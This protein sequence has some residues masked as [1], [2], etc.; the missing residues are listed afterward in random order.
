MKVKFNIHSFI[1]IITNS[2]TEIFCKIKGKTKEIIEKMIKSIMKEIGCT[3]VDFTVEQG[4][5]E[6]DNEIEGLY[7]IWYDYEINHEPCLYIK[8]RFKEI[9]GESI[10]DD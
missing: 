4:T 10:I 9:F 8:K 6:D 2:S 7:E 3:G 5:D 1:D